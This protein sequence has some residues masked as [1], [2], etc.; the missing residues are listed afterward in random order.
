M[1]CCKELKK[2]IRLPWRP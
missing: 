1:V 2:I